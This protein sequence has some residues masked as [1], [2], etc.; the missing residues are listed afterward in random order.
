[1]NKS[2]TFNEKLDVTLE[3]TIDGK[4]IKIWGANVKN[5]ELELLSHGFSGCLD[6]WVN[7][8]VD[9]DGDS[10]DL[11]KEPFQTNKLVEVK[12]EIFV[13]RPDRND[14]ERDPDPLRLRGFVI[15]K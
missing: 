2:P 12:L 6:F 13:L 15:E 11:L 9:M 5:L 3:L 4:V 1:M 8:D 10:E 7:D 14:V